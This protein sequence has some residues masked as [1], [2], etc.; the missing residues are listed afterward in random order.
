MLYRAL[1]CLTYV[2]LLTFLGGMLFY[3]CQTAHSKRLA[4]NEEGE[5]K[6]GL[7]VDLN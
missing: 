2:E 1:R 3:L 4:G 5:R 6:G 7:R